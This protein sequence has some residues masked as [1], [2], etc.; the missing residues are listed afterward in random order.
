MR[1]VFQ[2]GEVFSGEQGYY[3]LAHQIGE[4]GMG[5][6]WQAT[7][8]R[9]NY[10]VAIKFM[11]DDSA[12]L[13]VR[14]KREASILRALH[15][16]C[17]IR[18]IDDGETPDGRPFLVLELLTGQ[19][20]H[21]FLRKHGALPVKTA[22]QIARDVVS[23]L[24]AAHDA[25]IVHRDLKPGNVFLHDSSESNGRQVDVLIFDFGI[26]KDLGSSNEAYATAVGTVL[27][28]HGYMSPEQVRGRSVDRKADIWAVGMLLFEMIEGRGMFF[29]TAEQM[30][31]QVLSAPLTPIPWRVKDVPK[32]VD[33]IVGACLEREAAR[34]TITTH[35]L[36]IRLTQLLES[37]AIW[38]SAAEGPSP[39]TVVIERP[40]QTNA[41]PV[42]PPI[43]APSAMNAAYPA[44]ISV[45]EV[46]E[47]RSKSFDE[48]C[49]TLRR[50]ARYT[51]Y[52]SM[53]AF[54]FLVVAAT[55]VTGVVGYARPGTNPPNTVEPH[56]HTNND[57]G[58]PNPEKAP[59]N[60]APACP[61]VPPTP[62]IPPTPTTQE[63]ARIAPGQTPAA[64][65][66]TTARTPP[67]RRP[68]T[69]P[70]PKGSV[71]IQPPSPERLDNAPRGMSDHT[72]LDSYE[73]KHESAQ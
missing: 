10:Q 43:D 9:F 67:S 58:P 50:Q 32:E 22:V 25:G 33:L 7:D 40:R 55:A 70:V 46:E 23:A 41:R 12:A 35:E 17:I 18:I 6:V 49:D 13:R 42:A 27:G 56:Q 44:V 68:T 3:R 37:E 48:L 66:T 5:E 31:R 14:F 30:I 26:A 47:C 28:S 4:G 39:S 73:S 69:S 59:S 64:T 15:H 11:R 62:T 54:G 16:P 60:A 8:L 1:P 57:P 19:T 21:A 61:P 53:T 72:K 2:V 65:A 52:V 38:Q 34:R 29:G 24:A 36:A 20:L 63:E 45:H 51:Q 71:E